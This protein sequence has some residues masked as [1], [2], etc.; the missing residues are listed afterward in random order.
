[1]ANRAGYKQLPRRFCLPRPGGLFDRC[2]HYCIMP[3]R[4]RK[5]EPASG[6]EWSRELL[7]TWTRQARIGD[8]VTTCLLLTFLPSF[9]RFFPPSSAYIKHPISVPRPQIFGTNA[10]ARHAPDPKM[11]Q[12]TA[13]AIPPYV[14]L[15][16]PPCAASLLP[17]RYLLRPY[18]IA[19]TPQASPPNTEFALGSH[20]E[21]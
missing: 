4:A 21:G 13:P 9:S 3:G 14:R 12:Q 19:T 8:T 6:L 5:G 20:I 15:A 7:S 16:T 17:C 11:K 10:F 18:P 1:M 2:N